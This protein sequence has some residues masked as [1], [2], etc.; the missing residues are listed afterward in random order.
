MKQK[1]LVLDVGGTMIKYAVMD[2]AATIITQGETPTPHTTLEDFIEII[3]QLYEPLQLEVNGIA[4]SMPG[5]IDKDKGQIYAP[6]AL[7]YNANVNII[8]KIQERL[9]VR[10]SVENDGKCAAL[11]E[12]W[13][14]NLKDVQNGVV[15]VIGSGIG[16]GIIHERKL[17][18]GSHFFAGEVS[19]MKSDLAS[20]GFQSIFAMQASTSALVTRVANEK[21]IPVEEC[22][23]K[24]VF[25]WIHEQ[26]EIA[27][28]CFQDL[29]HVL[30]SQMYN[31]Q[32]LLDPDKILIGGGISK[33]PLLLETIK[34]K[35]E[36]Q[37]AALPFPIPHAV[38]D[39]CAFYNDSNLIGALYN[40]LN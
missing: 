9:K 5:N 20:D 36:E 11:A 26:D 4:L 37:Y 32:C 3:C 6:G 10:V 23:G 8:K 2:E 12:I 24:R 30:A 1:T 29:C 38:V 13:K 18:K 39:T 19:Y 22:N 40:Y 21:H 7:F 31:L 28:A 16:G 33:Q 27:C 34:Q 25:E 17:I 14:G 15:L 35:L